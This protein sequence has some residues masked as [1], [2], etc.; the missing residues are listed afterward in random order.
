M[1][2]HQDEW[3]NNHTRQFHKASENLLPVKPNDRMSY[4][5][6]SESKSVQSKQI[7][8]SPE[9]GTAVQEAVVTT[10]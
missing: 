8:T 4:N 3:Q 5:T 7:T 1:R 6:Y 9:T 10:H 2:D